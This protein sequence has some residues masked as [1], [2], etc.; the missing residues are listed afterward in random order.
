MTLSDLSI[1]NPVFAWMLMAALIIFGGISFMRLGVSQMPDVDFPVVNVSVTMEGAAP[2]IMESDVADVIEEAVS[3]VEGIREVSSSSR[4]GATNITIE[5]ELGRE[6]D[7]ALQDVQSK[8]AQA[9][10]NLPREIDPPI[11]TK[12]N[13]EDQPIMWIAL[14]GNRPP[15]DLADLVKNKL[16]DEFQTVP[17]VGNIFLGGYRERSVRVWLDARRL[18]AYGLSV[19]DVLDALRRQHV[20]I[21]AGRIESAEREMN[22]RAEGEAPTVQEFGDIVVAERQGS[23]IHLND[24]AVV[25][26]GL[27]DKRR[28]SRTMGVTAQ[29][30]GVVKQRGSNAVE[31]GQA[32]KA[33][34]AD[35]RKRLPS[36]LSLDIVFDGT[37]PVEEAI[38][39]IEFTLILSVLLTGLVCWLFLGSFSSTLNVLLSIPTSIIGTFAV[40]YFCG[41]TLN[42]FTL[43]GLSLAVGIVVDDAIMV[44]EN[45]YRHAEH[46]ASKLKASIE[47]AREITFAAMAATAAI[48]AI[49]LPVAFMKGIIGKFFF[50]FGVTVSVAVAFSLLEA[51]TLTPSR[52]SQFMSVGERTTRIGRAAEAAFTSLARLYGRVLGPTLRHRFLVLGGTLAVFAAS[53]LLLMGVNREFVPSQDIGRVLARIQTPVGSSVD[54]TDEMVK[55]CEQWVLTR[56]EVER[57]FAAVGGFGGGEVNSA[58]LFVTLKPR[59]ERTVT[60]AQFM[61]DMRKTLNTIP[62]L[63][64]TIQDLSQ[65]GFTAQRGFP[66]EFTVRGGDWSVLADSA[67]KIMDGMK[68]SPL[69]VDVDTDYQLGMPE[70]QILPNRKLAADLGVSMQE[71]GDTLNALIG[72]VRAVKFKDKGKRYDVRVRLL[73]DQRLRPEDIAPL[74]VRARDGQMVRLTDLVDVQVKPSLLSITRKNKSRAIGVFANV[75][76]GKSQATALQEVQKIAKGVLP[77]GYEVVLSGSAQTFQESMQSLLF[78]LLLGVIVSYMVLA[79]QF[80]SFIH[81]VTVL[82]ALPFSFTGAVLAL[83]LTGKSLNIYS[84]IGIILLMGIVKK[85]SII[86]VDY[87]NQLRR[88]GRGREEALL[89]ACPVRLRPILMTSLATIAGALPAAISFGPGAELRQPMALAVIGGVV[90]STF[91]TLFAVPAAYHLFDAWL[92]RRREAFEKSYAEAVA[93]TGVASPAP[94]ERGT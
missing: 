26:D 91:L 70:V 67:A 85:N 10:R 25:Q 15:Q 21:P 41:F 28:I 64:V 87:T 53:L 51:I 92:G 44:L 80:N 42:T 29:G 23:Q 90:V 46:G 75:A 43:L 31:V 52:C 61:A 94:L 34:M 16:K 81:P 88:A 48:I 47:G 18:E 54:Y 7:A 38:H 9:Q 13:P 56:P 77:E 82:M 24:V 93:A 89:E 20:E 17:G 33:K 62:S 45:I 66:V 19:S 60:Q 71:I 32:V 12:V 84:M 83:F 58:V 49:F 79:S 36:D 1:R 30:M 22:V 8:I 86:L 14:S 39:E 35:I 68:A 63:R 6:I 27:E 37:K 50:Q 11:T 4:Q 76:A 74:F 59:S 5:F 40:M 65:A 69:F 73:A 55:K 3:T 2:E 78:A 57:Y 72:G